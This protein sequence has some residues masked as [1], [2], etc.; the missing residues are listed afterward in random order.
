MHPVQVKYAA[1]KRCGRVSHGK[2]GALMTSAAFVLVQNC[3]G[4]RRGLLGTL[5]RSFYERRF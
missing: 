4:A 1:A 2:C 5:L 3:A